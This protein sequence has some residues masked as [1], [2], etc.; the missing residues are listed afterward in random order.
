VDTLRTRRAFAVTAS[1]V[2]KYAGYGTWWEVL[3]R[4]AEEARKVSRGA[5]PE[6]A[7]LLQNNPDPLHCAKQL[8]IHLGPHFR[9]VIRTEFGPNGVTPHD[10]LYRIANLPFDHVL[11]LNFDTSLERVHEELGKAATSISV[12]NRAE[13]LEFLR[14]IAAD[15]YDRKVVHLHG[16]FSDD[17]DEIAL[18]NQGY[19]RLY[20]ENTFLNKVLWMFAVSRPL[21]FLGYGFNDDVFNGALR[22]AAWD[23]EDNDEPRHFCIMGIWP[24]D[25][26]V[27]IRNNHNDSYRVQPI[28]YDLRG[29]PENPEHQG[30]VELVTG[31]SEEMRVTGKPLPVVAPQPAPQLPPAAQDLRRAQEMGD[32]LLER[33]DPGGN[34]VQG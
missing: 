28:F 27:G 33:A 24:E 8:A 9:G 32:A 6:P 3:H 15:G 12:T 25:N 4:F 18:T 31:I 21:I 14:S 1:G 17:P 22:A 30:F 13:L 29:T 10:V 2:S 16:L 26:D 20:H 34:D 23:A 19:R 11:T 7:V 5:I